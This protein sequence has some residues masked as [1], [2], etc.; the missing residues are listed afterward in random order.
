MGEGIK[1]VIVDKVTPCDAVLTA[2]IVMN[3]TKKL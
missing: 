3:V 1:R 2:E